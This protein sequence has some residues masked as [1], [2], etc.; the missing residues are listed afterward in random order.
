MSFLL[1]FSFPV[2]WCFCWPSLVLFCGFRACLGFITACIAFLVACLVFSEVTLFPSFLWFEFAVF[3]CCCWPLL[4]LLWCSLVE[5]T[6]CVPRRSPWQQF[7]RPRKS[8]HDFSLAGRGARSRSPGIF[9]V[10]ARIVATA[11]AGTQEVGSTS[12][13]H[14]NQFALIA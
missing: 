11:T 1:W 13:H 2:V 9:C 8:C 5:P 6:P 10:G 4:V 7:W 3:W 14:N 12:E